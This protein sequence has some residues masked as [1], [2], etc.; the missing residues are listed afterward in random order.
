MMRMMRRRNKLLSAGFGELG[1]MGIIF[2]LSNLLMF[3]ITQNFCIQ[4]GTPYETGFLDWCSEEC[5]EKWIVVKNWWDKNGAAQ[6]K[7]YGTIHHCIFDCIDCKEKAYW[8]G[9]LHADGTGIKNRTVSLPQHVKDVE[10]LDKWIE[11][12]GVDPNRKL[13]VGREKQPNQFEVRFANFHLSNQL[14]RL[15]VVPNKAKYLRLPQT[16]NRELLLSW[17]MGYYDGDGQ[18]NCTRIYAQSLGLV[19]DIKQAFNINSQIRHQINHW[20][21]CYEMA[22]GVALLDEM[23][24]NYPQS[25]PRKRYGRRHRRKFKPDEKRLLTSDE[26]SL[27]GRQGAKRSFEAD[28]L[29]LAQQVQKLPMTAVGKIYGVSCN[30]IRKRCRRLEISWPQNRRGYWAKKRSKS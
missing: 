8:L 22:L 28:P 21:E 5:Q 16:D 27:I 6:S 3:Q 14:K 25:L 15:G 20:G 18:A 30:A 29:E 10:I 17:L 13:S 1:K 19:K 9:M 4:C 12:I 2:S 24:S 26:L 23:T 11:F 7:I